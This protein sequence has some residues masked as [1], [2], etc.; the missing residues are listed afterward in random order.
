ME[1]LNN[2]LFLLIVSNQPAVISPKIVTSA[3]TLCFKTLVQVSTPAEIAR[4][5]NI[6]IG[7]ATIYCRR[8]RSSEFEERR[9]EEA[10]SSRDRVSASGTGR[11]LVRTASIVSSNESFKSCSDFSEPAWEVS[12]CGW[13]SV[14]DIR[15]G[16]RCAYL[17]LDR[18]FL[19]QSLKDEGMY[20]LVEAMECQ[21][22]L[23]PPLY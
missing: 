1:V 14:R 19:L 6:A 16:R 20:R 4:G 7:K 3:S 10:L 21:P 23:I 15:V 18:I 17:L 11:D 22:Y 13:L 2:P 9:T 12:A 8:S 5:V